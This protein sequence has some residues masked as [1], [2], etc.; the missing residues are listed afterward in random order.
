[1]CPAD[2]ARKSCSIDR[3]GVA[4]PTYPDADPLDPTLDEADFE[5]IF[6]EP[7]AERC[8]DF[9]ETLCLLGNHYTAKGFYEKGLQMDLRLAR[10]APNDPVVH[11]NLGCSYALTERNDEALRILDRAVD[12]GYDDLEHMTAD[13]DL[14]NLRD[15]PRYQDLL[16]RIG[17]PG[18][19]V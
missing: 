6:L 1:M 13:A 8:P 9:F 12:L 14:D 2:Y 11:Y 5:I 10:M 4:G 17:L 16:R 15:D 3:T 19:M 7:I 18:A